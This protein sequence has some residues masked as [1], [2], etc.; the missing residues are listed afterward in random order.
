[1]ESWLNELIKKFLG[2][3][4]SFSIN[5]GQILPVIYTDFMRLLSQFHYGTTQAI[6]DDKFL[7]TDWSFYNE[8]GSEL[9]QKNHGVI[10]AVM[11][12]HRMAIK[13]GLPKKT[14]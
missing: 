7:S 4:P 14:P 10:G 8:L 5:I 11:L 9:M 2:V 3:E 12:C 6:L 13:R 1:M